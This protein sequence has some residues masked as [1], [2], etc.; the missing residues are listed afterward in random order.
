M[1]APNIHQFMPS[2]HSIIKVADFDYD[3][4][5]LAEYLL[6][7]DKHDDEYNKY[8]EWKQKP[9]TGNFKKLQD[10]VKVDARCKLC[11]FLN[12]LPLPIHRSTTTNS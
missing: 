8:L 9:L 3:Y 5:K 2:N 4:K 7:L 11:M 6:Y 1:G 12:G 10:Y